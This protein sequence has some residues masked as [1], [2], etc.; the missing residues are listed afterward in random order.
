MCSRDNGSG[1]PVS[2]LP[3]AGPPPAAASEALPSAPSPS[4]RLPR[5]GAAPPPVQPPVAAASG[6][7]GRPDCASSVALAH[8]PLPAPDPQQ[9]QSVSSL[10]LSFSYKS[11]IMI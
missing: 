10:R 9:F 4:G 6:L 3:V 5:P 1:P 8:G 2:V 7:T 11:T